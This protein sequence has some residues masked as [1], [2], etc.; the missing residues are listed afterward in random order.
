MSIEIYGKAHFFKLTD[1]EL[2]AQPKEHVFRLGYWSQYP[3]LHAHIVKWFTEGQETYHDIE[4]HIDAM[5]EII[6]AIDKD[7]LPNTEGLTLCE[8]SKAAQQKAEAIETFGN[9]IDWLM[10]EDGETRRS[11]HYRGGW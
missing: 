4:L 10:V 2:K 6:H 9:A 8:K 7:R 3:D 1:E 11:V 5:F